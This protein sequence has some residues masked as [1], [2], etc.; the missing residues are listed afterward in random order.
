MHKYPLNVLKLY[1]KVYLTIPKFNMKL[2]NALNPKSNKCH[3]VMEAI[4]L[5]CRNMHRNWE[6]K[7]FGVRVKT[8]CQFNGRS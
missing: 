1:N 6:V 8:K 5:K 2:S 7:V 4:K 3:A